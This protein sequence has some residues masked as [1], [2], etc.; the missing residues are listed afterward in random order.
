[1]TEEPQQQPSIQ[2]RIAALN[3]GQVGKAPITATPCS[4]PVSRPSLDFRRASTIIPTQSMISSQNNGIGNEPIGP[5]RPPVLPPP[6]IKRSGPATNL[7]AA[8]APPPRL[9]PRNNS[10]QISKASPALPPR[11]PSEQLTR[12]DSSESMSSV[13][14][15]MSS[16]SAVSNGTART[17][18]SRAASMEA[19]R[20]R[21]PVYDPSSLPPLPPKRL[22][23]KK[24]E[25]F[26]RIPLKGTKST[27]N[28][29]TTEVLTSP[30][31]PALPQRPNER[32]RSREPA[33]QL[34]PRE[35]PPTPTRPVLSPTVIGINGIT[36]GHIQKATP[37]PIPMSSRPDLSR[38]L[39]TKPKISSVLP[40]TGP[41]PTARSLDSC[42]KCRNFS[43][44]DNHAAMFPRHSVPSL[45]WLATELT[46][47]FSSD[48]DKA[49]AVFTWLHHNVSY[50]VEAFFNNRVQAST[51]IS[52]LST[53][54]AVCEGYA[55]LFTTLATKAGLQS[56]VV[57]GHGK[58]FGIEPIAPGA[59]IPP[60][61]MNHTWN[62]VKID[63]GE[64]KL[65]DTCWGA[66][67]VNGKGKPYN[68]NFK[69]NHFTMDNDE[70]GL[71]HFPTNRS[72]F[73]R[74]DGRAQISWEEYILGDQGG[75]G[76]RV[77]SNIAPQEGLSSTK[78]LPKYLKLPISPAAH[79]GPTV[80]FQ[81]EKVC[82][83]W[84]ALAHGKG[85]P[86]VYILSIHGIDGRE[87]DYVPFDTNGMSWWA[88]VPPEKLGARGQT[89]TLYIVDTVQ[90]TTGRGL[91]KEEYQMAKGRKA[92]GFQGVAAWELV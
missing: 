41:R 9:P 59:P 67:D 40:S 6:T 7:S 13:I 66:G 44:P 49:R 26:T 18:G 16:L 55:A 54:L 77:F 61:S 38:I 63:D 37:P 76:A 92:M 78:F 87:D 36:N 68:K 83:H 22:L 29:T 75:E 20:L 82:P 33:R 34:P 51:P 3:L 62:A 45:D 32:E 2:A 19:P 81:L 64:W 47:P 12:R 17:S 30:R 73:Y 89:I 5:S 52:T 50:D 90:G 43:G 65:I 58:G 28:V 15:T 31:V 48:T 1:M 21:V 80:R 14:S 86:Y 46:A 88:D 57:S 53:G 56:I 71:C 8:P 69:P 84:D 24:E 70:F 91:S 85:K 72:H 27:P 39:A 60:Q 10:A 4:R 35:L 42:L 25:L 74:T 79:A 23:Q 11:R